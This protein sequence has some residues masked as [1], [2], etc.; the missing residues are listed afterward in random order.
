MSLQTFSQKITLDNK[1]DTNICFTIGQGRFII[2]QSIQ[3]KKLTEEKSLYQKLYENE[4][5]EVKKQKEIIY[6]DSLSKI[7]LTNVNKK[8]EEQSY[9]KEQKIIGLNTTIKEKDKSITRQKI[10]K[11]VFIV[12]GGVATSYE[13]Y[14]LLKK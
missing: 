6:R 11:W 2:A 3:V 9:L 14:L 10:Y 12:I 5:N 1:Q 8:T 13:S 4:K 7:D